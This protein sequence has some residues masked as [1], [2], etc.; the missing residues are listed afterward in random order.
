MN[1]TIK[2]SLLLFFSFF[3]FSSCSYF[4]KRERKK[5]RNER[6]LRIEAC[7]KDKPHVIFDS[8]WWPRYSLEEQ[9]FAERHKGEVFG[10]ELY[11][12]DIFKVEDTIYMLC[13]QWNSEFLLTIPDSELVEFLLEEY[14][15]WD[16]YFTFT[17]EDSI[18]TT[19]NKTHLTDVSIENNKMLDYYI[20]EGSKI[21]V[22][23][24]GT[25]VGI[26]N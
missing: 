8:S 6:K 23:F 25:L 21:K 17:I 16:N 1:R 14:S 19:E 4:E 9:L 15:P 2:H 3:V 24:R 18:L 20:E 5:L 12:E 26:C 22:L 7:K 13:S 11:L 10:S